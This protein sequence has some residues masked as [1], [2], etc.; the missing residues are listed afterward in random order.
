M[1]DSLLKYTK[2]GYN[3]KYDVYCSQYHAKKSAESIYFEEI[4]YTK[5]KEII[6][7]KWKWEIYQIRINNETAWKKIKKLILIEEK[8]P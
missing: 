5:E 8:T 1:K 6:R 7:K 4:E 2:K 3:E